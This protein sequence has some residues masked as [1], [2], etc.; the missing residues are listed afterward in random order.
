[1]GKQVDAIAVGSV[2]VGLI[3]LW[4]GLKG[5]SVITTV[6]EL[7]QGKQPTFAPAHSI[8]LASSVG[9]P[10]VAGAAPAAGNGSKASNQAIAKQLAAPYGWSTGSNWNS[11]VQLWDHESNWN[12]RAVN[13]SSGATGI[14][15]ALPASKMPKAAQSPTFDPAAQIGWGLSYIKNRPDYGSPDKAW[16]LWQSRSP[17]W[18]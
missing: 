9:N 18:Y 6:Q 14:P 1:M 17:H 8:D 13:P 11:L 7:I 2:G 12:N 3:F 5:A 10:T 16:A 4:S 15:Q